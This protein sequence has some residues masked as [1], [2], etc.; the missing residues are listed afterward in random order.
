M[1]TPCGHGSEKHA[2]EGILQSE[3]QLAHGRGGAA[4]SSESRVRGAGRRARNG[5][6]RK[7]IG[8]R[9]TPIRMIQN[10]ESL[11]PKLKLMMLVYE[12]SFV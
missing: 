5:G 1:G 6:A 8:G 4:D 2:L 3:L 7:N 9:F 10:I 12:E 11:E